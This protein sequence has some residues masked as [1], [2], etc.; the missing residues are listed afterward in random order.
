MCHR[1]MARLLA[2]LSTLFLFT[3]P[4]LNHWMT[5]LNLRHGET[6]QNEY[7]EKGIIRLD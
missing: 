1:D 7:I 6:F 4:L 2:I 5:S 3:E